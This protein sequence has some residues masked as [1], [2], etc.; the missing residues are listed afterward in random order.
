MYGYMAVH[1]F[2]FCFI[3]TN[4]FYDGKLQYS[5]SHGC[6]YHF[7]LSLPDEVQDV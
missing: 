4:L 2:C 3:N 7:D 1:L 6:K 5:V